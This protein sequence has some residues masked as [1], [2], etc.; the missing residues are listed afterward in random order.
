M[1][2]G[3]IHLGEE[4]LWKG[5]KPN[6]SVLLKLG[7]SLQNSA[8]QWFA[9]TAAE[10]LRYSMR[11][12]KLER[13]EERARMFAALAKTGLP[14]EAADRDPWTLS[15]GQ[16]RRLAMACLHAAEPEWLLLDE[17]TAGLDAAG[18]R[19]LCAELEAH[20]A[21]G[22]GAVVA[23]HDLDALWLLADDIVVI[24]DG[25]VREAVPAAAWAEHAAAGGATARGLPALPQALAAAA[26][27][28]AA[29][30]ALP[31]AA[32]ASPAAL[33]QALAAQ[34]RRGGVLAA[35]AATPAA[36]GAAA[37]AARVAALAAG[38]SPVA[39]A[40]GAYSAADAAGASSVADAAC[41]GT[42]AS[43]A[44][45]AFDA[46]RPVPDHACADRPAEAA[47]L[48]PAQAAAASSRKLQS[49][50]W[51]DRDPRTLWAAYMLVSTGLFMQHS[52]MGVACGALAAAV[53]LWNVRMSIRSF[54]KAAV[55]YLTFM[56]V[57][58][59]F[60]GLELN[61][62]TFSLS[63]AEENGKKMSVLA[64]VMLLGLPLLSLMSPFRLQRAIEQTM[65][66]LEKLGLPIRS[67]SL[68][69]ALLFRFIPLLGG[70]W[71]RFAKIA[72]ARGK[73]SVRPGTLPIRLLH[74]VLIPF[75]L[76]VLRLGE[77]VTVAL[78]VRGFTRPL[79]QTTRAVK[80]RFSVSDWLFLA[81]AAGI[82]VLLY[83]VSLKFA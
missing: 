21:G 62:F 48:N 73:I 74:T 55:F 54:R 14:P 49:H 56:L 26:A 3:T 10:E 81:A 75:L 64:M 50:P 53:L 13:S 70:E 6:L 79:N 67:F 69:I 58:L 19:R 59:I 38:A 65:L 18:I 72:V 12:Y 23:T 77:R 7:V 68:T 4:P 83:I 71:I 82:F 46:V 15:G 5:A 24:D 47:S 31:S 36:E 39:D 61:P 63:A 9:R 30:F 41:P 16:Q 78:E 29:G 66:P 28:R 45:P 2:E 8:S 51:S 11:P 52:W 40:A 33:A 32:A 60:S 17:P 34:L 80:L 20:K 22:R 44:S 37:A 57:M 35:E 25:V 1:A 42:G 43:A 76:S 27:L